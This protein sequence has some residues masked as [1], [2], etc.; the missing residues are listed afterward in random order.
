MD[1]G[2]IQRQIDRHREQVEQLTK[3]MTERELTGQRRIAQLC[4]EQSSMIEAMQSQITRHE[5]I[6][7]DLEQFLKE[8]NGECPHEYSNCT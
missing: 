6:A 2:F 7:S 4:K 3:C 1:R 5:K 8:H